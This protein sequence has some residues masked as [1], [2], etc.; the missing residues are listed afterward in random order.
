MRPDLQQFWHE[1][2]RPRAW[3]WY[4]ASISVLAFGFWMSAQYY[5]GGFDWRYRVASAL[6]SRLDNPRGSYWSAAGL[7]LSM[8]LMWP[9]VSAVKRRMNASANAW[10]RFAFGA[11]RTGLACGML[12][13][14]E[15]LLIQNLS[16][17]ITKGHEIVALA[18][19]FSLD[20]GVFIL[21]VQ[22]LVRRRIYAVPALLIL[23]PLLAVAFNQFWLW[24]AQ[25]DIGWIHT[26]WKRLGIPLWFS[27]AFWQWQA[28]T[29]VNLGLGLLD[30]IAGERHEP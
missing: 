27:F 23:L 16:S 21:L 13:S 7:G 18:T 24:L 29:F 11:L 17:L 9:Y 22:A 1:L 4:I 26:D 15:R 20:I 28:I 8:I 5:P 12:L 3:W 6:A 10:T 25:R 19:F 14:G 2:L 30:F